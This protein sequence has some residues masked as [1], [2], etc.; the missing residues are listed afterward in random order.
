MLAGR[1]A[2]FRTGDSLRLRARAENG[3]LFVTVGVS[4]A[5]LAA[6]NGGYFPST[7]SWASLAF[8]ALAV[9]LLLRPQAGVDRAAALFLVLLAALV[10]WSLA[11]VLWS[12]AGEAV[13]ATERTFVY[14]S[15]AAAVFL[16]VGRRSVPTLLGGV[17]AGLVIVDVY[18]LATRLLPDRVG[19]STVVADRLAAPVGYWN[20]LGLATVIA[21]LLAL[22]FAVRGRSAAGRVVA[23]SALPPQASTT[24]LPR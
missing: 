2:S 13:F 8:S 17:V 19:R 11:S 4:V 3:A 12:P 5:T 9:A 15:A 14:L 18:A 7:W 10:A 23:A 22:G 20:G 6:A 1:V 21:V 16:G 24:S